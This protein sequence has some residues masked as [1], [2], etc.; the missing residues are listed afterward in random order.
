MVKINQKVKNDFEKGRAAKQ[1]AQKFKFGPL[2][3][4]LGLKAKKVALKDNENHQN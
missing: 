4:N 3:P 2:S 1:R